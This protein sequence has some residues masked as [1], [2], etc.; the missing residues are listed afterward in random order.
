MDEH[1]APCLSSVSYYSSSDSGPSEQECHELFHQ[2][3]PACSLVDPQQYAPCGHCQ[4]LRLRHLIK[5]V[6]PVTRNRFLF[7]LRKGLAEDANVTEC[8]FCRLINH[9]I[10]AGLSPAQLLEVRAADYEIVLY[11]GLPQD[12]QS[13]RS[14]AFSAEIWAHYPEDG[15][16]ATM[17]IGDIYIDDAKIGMIFDSVPVC[18]ITLPESESPNCVSCEWNN[19]LGVLIGQ[20]RRMLRNAQRVSTKTQS[21]SWISGH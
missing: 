13:E 5:C 11:P 19:I 16:V 18:I 12:S 9:M 7:T 17:W 15:G 21:S 20:D 2:P 3:C 1:C 10:V 8:R 14:D 6:D 4:H